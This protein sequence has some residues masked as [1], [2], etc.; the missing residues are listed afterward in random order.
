V[1]AHVAAASKPTEQLDGVVEDLVVDDRVNGRIYHFPQLRLPDGSTVALTRLAGGRDIAIGVQTL[2][3]RDDPNALR[4]TVLLAAAV[5]AG[6]AAA[7]AIGFARGDGIAR[8][9][10]TN[11]PFA[12]AAAGAGAYLAGRLRRGS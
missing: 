7:F 3:A 1:E 2:W 11:F 5:D 6:D 12:A 8:A 9:A 4:R 10:A